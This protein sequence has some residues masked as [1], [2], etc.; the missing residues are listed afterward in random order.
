[1]TVRFDTLLLSFKG[2]GE[3]ADQK[4]RSCNTVSRFVAAP[5]LI[6]FETQNVSTRTND[7]QAGEIAPGPNTSSSEDIQNIHLIPD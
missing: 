7:S 6:T 2:I 3:A 4:S 5:A 1:M